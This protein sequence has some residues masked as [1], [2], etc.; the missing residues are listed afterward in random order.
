MLLEMAE[1]L[2][3]GEEDYGMLVGLYNSISKGL[4]TCGIVFFNGLTLLHTE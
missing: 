4:L 3:G 2:V 1:Q